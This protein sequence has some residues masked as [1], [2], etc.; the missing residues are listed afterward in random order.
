MGVF[1]KKSSSELSNI[2]C[3]GRFSPKNCPAWAK[4]DPKIHPRKSE[5]SIWDPS[6]GKFWWKMA[7]RASIWGFWWSFFS[8]HTHSTLYYSEIPKNYIWITFGNVYESNF[9][10][11]NEEIL[12]FHWSNF[13]QIALIQPSDPKFWPSTLIFWGTYLFLTPQNLHTYV[14]KCADYEYRIFRNF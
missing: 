6:Q 5:N 9:G 2:G 14:K 8:K 1:K 4:S 3:E 7:L 10:F 13:P 12:F 11:G